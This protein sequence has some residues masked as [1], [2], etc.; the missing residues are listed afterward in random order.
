[1]ASITSIVLADG[2]ATPVSHTFNRVPS[3]QSN[4]IAFR[5]ATAGLVSAARASI[6]GLFRPAASGNDGAKRVINVVVPEYD[7]TLKTIICTARVKIEILMPEAASDLTR[8][9][10]AAYLKNIAATA[11]VQN[12]VSLDDPMF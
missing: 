12:E 1:M 10:V 7:S 6:T 2:Q 4:I 9:N 11:A 3:T 8:K 5:D